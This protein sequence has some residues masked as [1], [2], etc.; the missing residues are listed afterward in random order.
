MALAGRSALVGVQDRV[1][2]RNASCTPRLVHVSA[3]G[4]L[5]AQLLTCNRAICPFL[6]FRALRCAARKWPVYRDFEMARPGLE[7][8]TPRF[9]GVRVSLSNRAKPPANKR[10]RAALQRA[11]N[12]RKF[13]SFFG[14]LGHGWRPVA[15]WCASAAATPH[16]GL[17]RACGGEVE[18]GV[19]GVVGA[20]VG[21]HLQQ[22]LRFQEDTRPRPPLTYEHEE[23]DGPI[24]SHRPVERGRRCCRCGANSPAS[25]R[26]G[27]PR[28]ETPTVCRAPGR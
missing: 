24:S 9:S 6:P 13:H 16:P 28:D 5:A 15:R 23:L 14:D 2:T 3:D 27:A 25:R 26:P 17:G 4:V 22:W 12:T 18:R 11:H 21:A 10:D 8:G 1:R 7:P 20:P 19:D